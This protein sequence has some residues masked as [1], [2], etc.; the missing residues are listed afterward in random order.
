TEGDDLW[1]MADADLVELAKR[2]IDRIGLARAAD[3]EDGCVVRV[4]KAYP[5][6]DA[7]Y[8]EHLA[9][10]RDYVSRLENFQPVGRNGLHRY[11]NQDHAM[12]TGMY[13]VRNLLL[14]ERHD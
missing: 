5:I 13:A 1:Q 6:Y 8:A 3:V 2:E 14:G 7:D 11:N 12:L 4:P 9:C 10:V